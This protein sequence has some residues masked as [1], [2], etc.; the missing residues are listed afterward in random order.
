MP[1][2]MRTVAGTI[3]RSG[4]A[5]QGNLTAPAGAD[6]PFNFFA[7]IPGKGQIIFLTRP[8]KIKRAEPSRPALLTS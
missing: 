7:W 3:V 4:T 5:V 1:V 6:V 2:M 8:S